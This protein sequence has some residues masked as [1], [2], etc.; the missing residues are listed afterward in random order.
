MLSRVIFTFGTKLLSAVLSF[1]I[2]VFTSK[3]IGAEGRGEI[4]LFVLGIT[5]TLLMN[6]IIGGSALIFLSSRIE[7]F[8][9][10][11]PSYI[12]SFISA[13]LVTFILTSFNLVPSYLITHILFISIIQSLAAVNQNLF[14]GQKKLKLFN[15]IS[16]LQVTILFTVLVSFLFILGKRSV[17]DYITAVYISFVLQMIISFWFVI[18]NLKLVA[19]K[20]QIEVVKTIIKNGLVI[21]LCN[22]VQL[23][24][25]RLCYFFLESEKGIATLGVFST[26]TAVAESVWLISKSISLVQYSEIANTTDPGYARRVSIRLSK[27]SFVLSFSAFIPILLIPSTIY[28]SIFGPEFEDIGKQ[29]YIYCPGILALSFSTVFAH[30]FAGLGRNSINT[31]CRTIYSIFWNQYYGKNQGNYKTR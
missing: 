20:H 16:L 14:I 2:V 25:Y 10:L 21:Q 5:L 24:N 8:R 30:F 7:P 11:I 31:N 26:A 1:L 9:L 19:P 12:W 28:G 17:N 3:L 18:K 4:S 22:V 27:L 6:N 23:L 29:I 15:L 13:L